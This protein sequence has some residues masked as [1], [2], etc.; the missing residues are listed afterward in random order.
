VLIFEGKHLMVRLPQ[1]FE[2][3]ILDDAK[4]AKIS[5]QEWISKIVKEHYAKRWAQN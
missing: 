2:G 4:A 3:Q 1:P 5:P